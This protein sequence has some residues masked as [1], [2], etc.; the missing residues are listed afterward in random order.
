MYS[1]V[2]AVYPDLRVAQERA[3]GPSGLTAVRIVQEAESSEYGACVFEMNNKIIRFR[4]AKI[5]PTKIGQFV[6]LWKRIGN[7]PIMPFD[8]ADAVDLFVVSV[9]KNDRCGQFVFSKEL[10]WQRGFV[11]CEGKGGKRAM[12]VYPPWDRPDSPQA[13]KTQAWQIGYFF[14]IKQGVVDTVRIQHLF[15]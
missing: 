13:L 5:T 1:L 15:R 2:D 4:T 8:K 11:S 10:L 14:E 9:R 12:R 6:T 7:G 3:Y